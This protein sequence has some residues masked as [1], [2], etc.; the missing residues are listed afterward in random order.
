MKFKAANVL[1][2]INAKAMENQTVN[3]INGIETYFPY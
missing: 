3:T 1:N 2:F